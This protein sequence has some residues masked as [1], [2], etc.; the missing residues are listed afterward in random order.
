MVPEVSSA[1]VL[2]V[3]PVPAFGLWVSVPAVWWVRVG[4]LH[5][6][7]PVVSSPLVVQAP[8]RK[9]SQ[10]GDVLILQPAVSSLLSRQEMVPE[11]S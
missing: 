1:G 7:A 10:S 8:L 11:T 5:V 9:V 2:K 3:V 4:V 6:P